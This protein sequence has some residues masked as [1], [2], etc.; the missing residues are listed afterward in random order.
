[1]KVFLSIWAN[2]LGHSAWVARS[3]VFTHSPHI[4]TLGLGIQLI[5]NCGN[6]P[7]YHDKLK[8]EKKSTVKWANVSN[9]IEIQVCDV[10]WGSVCHLNVF[11]RQLDEDIGFWFDPFRARSRHTSPSR[12]TANHLFAWYLTRARALPLPVPLTL[13]PSC[14]QISMHRTKHRHEPTPRYPLSR[15]NTQKMYQI[16]EWNRNSK[17]MCSWE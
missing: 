11:D 16:S 7:H 1:M 12:L 17:L 13:S 10:K 9:S 2:A 6:G 14:S 15:T 8:M 3:F 5:S 4:Y